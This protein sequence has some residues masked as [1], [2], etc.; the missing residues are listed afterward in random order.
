MK[1]KSCIAKNIRK[2]IEKD[3][4]KQCAVARKAGYSASAFSNML[5]GR[6]LIADYDIPRIA[7]ALG[8]SF[9]DLF[10]RTSEE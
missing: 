6:K 3:G 10:E 5:C 1:N 8:V 9:N 2:I 4:L 7:N